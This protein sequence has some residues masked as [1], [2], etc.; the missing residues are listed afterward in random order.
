MSGGEPSGVEREPGILDVLRI[1]EVRAAVV[2]TFVIML[3]F[4]IVSPVLPSYARSFDV[5]RDAVGLLISGF[6]FARLLS[7]PFVGQLIDRR[8]ERAMVTLGAAIVGVTSIAAGLAPTFPLL[9]AFR[10]LGGVGSA[11]FFAAMMSYLLRSIPQERSGRVMSVWYGAFNIGIIAGAP[12][13]GLVAGWWGRASPLHIYGGAC[14]VAAWLF[15]RRIHNPTRGAGE[16]RKGGFRRL[17]WGRPLAAALASN[18]A[19]LWVVGAVFSTLIPLFAKEELGLSD[20]GV[21]GAIAVLTVFEFAF[22]FPAGKATDRRGRRAVLIPALAS[23]AV[24]VALLGFATTPWIL[25]VGMALFGLAGAYAGVPPAPMLSDVT[26]EDLKGTAVAVFRFVGD[27]GFVLGP[28]L[29]GWTSEHLGFPAAFAISAIPLVVALA[30][31]LSIRETRSP[32][33]HTGEAVGL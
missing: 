27:V 28:L 11:L 20:A 25:L 21:G 15:W 3:G 31:V 4:G 26:P 14:F 5:G 9:V 23:F 30:L 7:G 2:G 17:P 33:P 22:L 19:Y 16:T 6:S 10:S 8:G 32:V 24:V 1:P 12:I 29:A 18:G 13:G